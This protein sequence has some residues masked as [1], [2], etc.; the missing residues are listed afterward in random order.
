MHIGERDRLV[1]YGAAMV[2]VSVYYAV[3]SLYTGCRIEAF[4]VSSR[5]G[6]PTEIDGIPVVAL[7]E[8]RDTDCKVLIAV[9]EEHHEVIT[10]ALAQRGFTKYICM[11]A[12][13]EAALMEEYYSRKGVFPSLRS[14]GG[15][16]GA[17]VSLN[18]YMSCFHRDKALKKRYDM[19]EWV[20]P[21]QAGAALT[22]ERIAAVCDNVGENISEKNKNYSELSALYWVGK[23][24]TADYLGLYHY[25]RTLDVTED[26]LDKI[27]GNGIDVILPFPTIHYPDILEHHGRYLKEAD[28]EAMVRALCE[29][30]PA[31]GEALPEIFSGPYFYN[32]NMLIAKRSVF[33]AYCDW[34]FPILART[35]ELSDPKGSERADRYIGY[36]GENLTTLYFMYHQKDL[37]IAHAGRRMLI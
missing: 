9:P 29:Q 14:Y 10:A 1:I 8:W 37:H 16:G 7:K 5:E 21:I 26:D 11:D 17:P 33:Q 24:G 20:Q 13:T 12:Q 15:G 23:H 32:Y 19:P 27:A 4:L 34:L 30:A 28:W 22:D 2:A 6:N 31:Y 36:L 18:I 35:E 3:K 25:R